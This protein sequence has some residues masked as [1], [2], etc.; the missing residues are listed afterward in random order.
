MAS[1]AQLANENN[2]VLALGDADI[3]LEELCKL[4]KK[5]KLILIDPPYNRKTKF[6]HYNDN[7]C[8]IEWS[9]TLEKHC[10]SLHECLDET[11]SLWMHIDD[12]E[13]ISARLMLNSIFGKKNFIANVIWQKS[14]SRDNRTTI[15][16]T[17]EYILVYAKDKSLWKSVRSKLPATEEQTSRYKNRDNDPRGAWTSGDL[18]A[19]A[20]PGRSVVVNHFWPPRYK[21]S[22]TVFLSL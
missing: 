7:T 15:S 2:S 20:G 16:T 4:K 22:N 18:T 11:G 19:K 6:H 8:S 17:H 12:S 10:R 21:F 13:M 1:L 9:Q 3:Y 14:V 5:P